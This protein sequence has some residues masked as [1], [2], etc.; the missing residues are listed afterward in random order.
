MKKDTETARQLNRG[1]AIKE[2]VKSDG[3]GIVRE[4]LVNKLIDLQSVRNI[5]T[6]NPEQAVQEIAVRRQVCDTIV[7]WLREVDSEI[8]QHLDNTAVLGN[9]D[10]IVRY[11]E[12]EQ[13]KEE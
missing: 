8:E 3:W 6:E 2:L 13:E 10:E 11:A 1:H 4:M 7:E 12:K 9:E 5:E